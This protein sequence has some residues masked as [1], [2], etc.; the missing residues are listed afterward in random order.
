MS[1]TVLFM[2]YWSLTTLQIC[3]QVQD[4]IIIPSWCSWSPI[5]HSEGNTKQSKITVACW[6]P[7]MCAISLESSPDSLLSMVSGVGAY[8]TI[9]SWWADMW[10]LWRAQNDLESPQNPMYSVINKTILQKKQ[11][12]TN[13]SKHCEWFL[14]SL[15]S[16]GFLMLLVLP[17]P[18]FC[19]WFLFPHCIHL[20]CVSSWLVCLFIPCCVCVTLQSLSES[21]VHFWTLFTIPCFLILPLTMGDLL[22]SV[23]SFSK[24]QCYGLWL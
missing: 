16:C 22:L 14:C 8:I 18:L 20:F 2:C 9:K 6:L 13:F 11:A 12:V 17:L 24:K 23:A 21:I 15:S 4:V 7:W 3:C 5:G 10:K 19:P 1:C